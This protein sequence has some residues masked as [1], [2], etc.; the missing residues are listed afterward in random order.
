MHLSN[1]SLSLIFFA[2]E[3]L[4][5]EGHKKIEGLEVSPL[6]IEYNGPIDIARVGDV[7]RITSSN[8]NRFEAKQFEIIAGVNGGWSVNKNY[9]RTTVPDV[10]NE[11]P[12]LRI[13]QV[14]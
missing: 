9:V 7:Y 13:Y 2:N 8:A 10:S 1:F 11:L 5:K 4:A 6:S 12:E 14:S 3:L